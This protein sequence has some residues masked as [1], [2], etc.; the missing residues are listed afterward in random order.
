M[1]CEI[2]G[3]DFIALGVHVRHKHHVAPADYK[4]EFGLLKTAALADSDLS[5]RLRRGALMRLKDADYRDEVTEQCKLN[6]KESAGRAYEMSD[7]GKA[8]LSD[9]NRAR[10]K[11][12]LRAKAQVVAPIIDERGTSLDVRRAIGVGHAAVQRMASMGLVTYERQRA[13]DERSARAAATHRAK[14][15]K[16]VEAVLP[17]LETT[18]SAAEMCRRA[19]I[20]IKTYKNWLEAGLI[21]R[22][23]NGTGRRAS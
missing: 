1:K 16:R 11:E 7:A 23:P 10:N 9:R 18:R 17:L 19:G 5:E 22:H 8:L 12:Y 20:S 21:P 14:A 3:R 15:T 4:E 6:A 2:C 13:V